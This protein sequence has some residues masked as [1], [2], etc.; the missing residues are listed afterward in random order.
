MISYEN[1]SN[2]VCE[3]LC[4]SSNSYMH[5]LISHRLHKQTNKQNLRS[6]KGLNSSDNSR[7]T[8][9][10]SIKLLFYAFDT[11]MIMNF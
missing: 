10:H 1:P 9:A 8:H 7:N 2:F 6:Q 11:V 3:S 5:C 4:F